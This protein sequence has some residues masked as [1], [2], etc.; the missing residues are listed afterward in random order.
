MTFNEFN[1][2]YEPCFYL[3]ILF[4][5]IF[6]IYLFYFFFF[7]NRI[8]KGENRIAVFSENSRTKYGK[9][10]LLG[11]SVWCISIDNKHKG[12]YHTLMFLICFQ[13]TMDKTIYLR[14]IVEL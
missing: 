9:I 11:M 14:Y 6:F 4:Y 8:F 13:F 3:F 5:L 1:D 7:Q 2:R 10:V 12:I